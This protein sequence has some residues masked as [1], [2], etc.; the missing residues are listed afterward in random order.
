MTF[1]NRVSSQQC[2][3]IPMEAFQLP[4]RAV[5]VK[6]A[7]SQA[8]PP[9]GWVLVHFCFIWLRETAAQMTGHPP[10]AGMRFRR[11]ALAQNK[12]SRL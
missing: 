12:L 2:S 8:L 6:R 11:E 4:L 3:G 5:R 10:P 1:Q 7:R 9:V